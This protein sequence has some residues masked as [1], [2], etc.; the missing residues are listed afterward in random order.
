MCT[1]YFFYFFYWSYHDFLY[2][3]F[4]EP[5]ISVNHTEHSSME[6]CA[7]EMGIII[8]VIIVVIVISRKDHSCL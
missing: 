6:L 7:V 8:I 2:L 4:F 1:V 3:L 5:E